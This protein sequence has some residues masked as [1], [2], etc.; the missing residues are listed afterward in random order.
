[1][2]FY[3]Y[4]IE[5]KYKMENVVEEYMNV[6]V[7]KNKKLWLIEMLGDNLDIIIIFF[8]MSV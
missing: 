6:D 7:V 8:K 2:I 1:M 4:E 3:V 5:N